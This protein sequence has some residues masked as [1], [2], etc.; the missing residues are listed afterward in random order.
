MQHALQ[1]VQH[2]LNFELAVEGG[3]KCTTIVVSPLAQLSLVSGS[4]EA[5]VFS[6]VQ[7][8]AQWM[9]LWCAHIRLT[10]ALAAGLT[11]S[12]DPLLRSTTTRHISRA[13]SIVQRICATVSF[14]LGELDSNGYPRNFGDVT[15]GPAPMLLAPVLFVVGTSFSI[16]TEPKAWICDRLAQIGHERGIGQALVFEKRLRG[17]TGV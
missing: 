2:L 7:L 3:L 11:I 4:Y 14:V 9:A 15:V 5:I 12:R 8:G 13:N 16:R 10:D 1:V 17:N 6:D